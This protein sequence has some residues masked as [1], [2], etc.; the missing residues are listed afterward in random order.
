MSDM[1][2]WLR[3]EEKRRTIQFDVKES[4]RNKNTKD[5][6]WLIKHIYVCA[7]QGSGGKSK[8]VPKHPDRVRN[9][10]ARRAE[11]G[12]P[13]RLTVKTYPDTTAVLG[14]YVAEHSHP[15]GDANVKYTRIP[16]HTRNEIEELL[17]KGMRPDLVV[18]ASLPS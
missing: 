11:E 5:H 17:R 15:I 2:V 13:C 6:H 4:R 18:S 12:C 1:S 7:R 9:I 16:P 3:D 10:P 8:Y 14:L